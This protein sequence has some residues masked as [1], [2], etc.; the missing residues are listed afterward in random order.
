MTSQY[1]DMDES[2]WSPTV[3][4]PQLSS[5]NSPSAVITSVPSTGITLVPS[6]D[7]TAIPSIAITTVPSIAITAIPSIAITTVPSDAINTVPSS[8]SS[9]VLSS[10][11]T[12]APPSVISSNPQVPL[13]TE[14]YVTP[15]GAAQLAVDSAQLTRENRHQDCLTVGPVTRP[16]LKGVTIKRSFKRKAPAPP[17]PSVM[18]MD[19]VTS[20]GPDDNVPVAPARSQSSHDATK[21]FQDNFP[22]ICE[23][24]ILE[25]TTYNQT[26]SFL[27]NEIFYQQAALAGYPENLYANVSLPTS[28]DMLKHPSFRYGVLPFAPRCADLYLP[29]PPSTWT[30]GLNHSLSEGCVQRGGVLP[31]SPS[32]SGPLIPVVEETVSPDGALVSHPYYQ[33]QVILQQKRT[34]KKSASPRCVHDEVSPNESP[35]EDCDDP[36]SQMY[37]GK[38]ATRKP[39]LSR[40]DSVITVAHLCEDLYVVSPMVRVTLT[41]LTGMV[42]VAALF[43]PNTA[44]LLYT[45]F[46]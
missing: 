33:Q 11:I 9:P 17:P 16:L 5:S 42:V 43:L 3:A 20:P 25:T 37:Y 8:V 26:H 10:G 31:T 4:T 28:P 23:G 36:Y 32:S 21:K 40:S 6:V 45:F 29:T 24:N 38:L 12:P 46:R 1:S 30:R 18:S 13:V 44:A 14:V 41:N 22:L 19:Q 2:V 27:N 39:R 7:I 35:N 15:I 34:R